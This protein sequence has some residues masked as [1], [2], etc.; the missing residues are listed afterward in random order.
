MGFGPSERQFQVVI[1][2]RDSMLSVGQLED[3][4]YVAVAAVTNHAPVIAGL[5]TGRLTL[6]RALADLDRGRGMPPAQAV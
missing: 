5:L 3:A 4:I 1:P 2:L 6:E